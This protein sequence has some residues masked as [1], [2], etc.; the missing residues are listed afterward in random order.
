MFTGYPTCKG[1]TANLNAY[2]E[3]TVKV[4]QIEDKGNGQNGV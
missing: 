4:Y 1:R 3:K 2:Q